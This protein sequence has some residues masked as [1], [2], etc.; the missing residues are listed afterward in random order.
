MTLDPVGSDERPPRQMAASEGATGATLA[1]PTAT[2]GR[3]VRGRS[4]RLLEAARHRG[5]A[6]GGRV[7]AIDDCKRQP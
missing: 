2:R 3:T 4:Q 7:G 5:A 1:R 6:G